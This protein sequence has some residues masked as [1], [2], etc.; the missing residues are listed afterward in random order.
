MYYYV[1][2]YF[3]IN[4]FLHNLRVDHKSQKNRRHK[5]SLYNIV[6]FFAHMYKKRKNSIHY[7]SS[8]LKKR[9]NKIL[10]NYSF[11]KNIPYIMYHNHRICTIIYNE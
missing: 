10:F 8:E 9:S 2:N 11:I 4:T 1:Q 3:R 7:L 5:K 6:Q